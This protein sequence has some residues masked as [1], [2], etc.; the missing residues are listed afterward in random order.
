LNVAVKRKHITANVA[1]LAKTPKVEEILHILQAAEQDRNSALWAIA[2][3]LGL[4]Q[5]EAL[6]LMWADV[7]LSAGTL[8]VRRSRLRPKRR[9]GC[10]ERCGRKHAGHC[11]DR[12]RCSTHV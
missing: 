7:D 9:H 5:G 6:G 10:A 8:V 1:T 4:R 2:L 12:V 3:A 11:P